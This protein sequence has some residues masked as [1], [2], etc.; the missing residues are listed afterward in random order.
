MAK[1]IS[2][3]VP[4]W[5]VE[6]FVDKCIE[7]ILSQSFNNFEIILINDGSTDN[8]VK[9]CEE[10]AKKDDRIRLVHKKHGGVSSARN[11]GLDNADGDYCLFVDSDDKLLPNAIELL[12]KL[13]E[14]NECQFVSSVE[15]KF[16]NGKKLIDIYN[17]KESFLRLISCSLYGVYKS[18]YNL[19]IIQENKIR[20]DEELKCSEDV[21]FN[22]VYLQFVKRMYITNQ[23][24][25]L[26]NIHN[27]NSL[28]KRYYVDFAD[29]FVK[30]L[31][32]L[33]ALSKTI[34]LNEQRKNNFITER[35][36]HGFK[37]SVEHYFL[38]F[39]SMNQTTDIQHQDFLKQKIDH[40]YEIFMPFITDSRHLPKKYKR[41]YNRYIKKF[42]VDSFY[43]RFKIEMKVYKFKLVIRQCI[44]KIIKR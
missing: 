8:S 37:I 31:N 29:Y 21:L 15:R 5:N 1:K 13:M 9:I 40:C 32:A 27:Q 4:V 26:Y 33:E 7:S 6:Q 17:D 22:R 24:V 14:K 10:Y 3:I 28:S 30:K 34:S 2:V 44:K 19:K 36:V 41:W 38:K 25:Y 16:Y 20:F 23:I 11:L 43:N 18:L 35:A 42:N 12:V 39:V